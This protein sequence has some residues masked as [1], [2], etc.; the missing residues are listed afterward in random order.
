MR[1]PVDRVACVNVL[2]FSLMAMAFDYCYT[3]TKAVYEE[4]RRIGRPE[5]AMSEEGGGCTDDRPER[6]ICAKVGFAVSVILQISTKFETGINFMRFLMHMSTPCKSV[7]LP[8]LPP[9]NLSH[10]RYYP[11][12]ICLTSET[13]PLQICL[14]S[15]TFSPPANLSRFFLVFFF[16]R[17]T[18]F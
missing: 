16:L 4:C 3:V 12:Q 11:L 10:F 7:P 13:T 8:V 9:A 2:F 1:E 5:G 14:T 18:I 15:E 17:G 6:A